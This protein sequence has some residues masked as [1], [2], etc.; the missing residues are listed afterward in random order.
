MTRRSRYV[1]RN[2]SFFVRRTT[3]PV[4]EIVM[5]NLFFLVSALGSVAA[6]GAQFGIFPVLSKHPSQKFVGST[7]LQDCK[8]ASNDVR[9]RFNEVDVVKAG[10][11]W[12]DGPCIRVNENQFQLVIAHERPVGEELNRF[13]I[14]LSSLNECEKELPNFYQRTLLAKT[15][16]IHAF[17]RGAEAHLEL[18]DTIPLAVSTYLSGGTHASNEECLKAAHKT[19][20]Q[21]LQAGFSPLWVSCRLHEKGELQVV[22]PYVFPVGKKLEHLAGPLTSNL[23][24]CGLSV[25]QVEED[26]SNRGLQ[27]LSSFCYEEK[28]GFRGK[29]TFVAS[30]MARFETEKLDGFN[31]VASCERSLL[32]LE[33]SLVRRG[34]VVVTS[35][36]ERADE[37]YR[38]RIHHMTKVAP[39][40]GLRR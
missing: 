19:S 13:V 33:Q 10:Y 39:A 28:Y 20:E 31:D 1:L 17:C 16:A 36:C 15:P 9:D 8:A 12:V 6:N 18:V 22:I 30:L 34:R 35:F 40:P 38:V 2:G 25:A 14:R 29:V 23:F 7:A 11:K 4:Y 3:I 21:M 32:A 37:D 24:N 27:P 5:L 26:L